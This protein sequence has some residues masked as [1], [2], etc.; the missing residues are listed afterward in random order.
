MTTSPFE[1]IIF[2][3]DGTLIDTESADLRA[4]Q[5]IY[6]EHGATI[7]PEY[8]AKHIVGYKDSA[9]LV[10]AD[11][12]QRNGHGLSAPVL[13]QRFRELWSNQLDRV[14]LLP[15]VPE[16]LLALQAFG[17]PLALAT[18]SD[19]TWTQRWLSHFNLSGYFQAIA[20]CE[21]V[22]CNKPAPDVY[23]FAAARIGVLPAR[24]LVFEDSLPGLA[25]AKSAG[26]TAVA[27]R[28]QA[29]Q[30]IEFSQADWVI[31]SLGSV[32]VEWIQNLNLQKSDV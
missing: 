7:S 28:H 8:W 25:A 3:L 4:C 31:N 10:V 2:D 20:T 11:L 27:V 16:L 15:G 6:Q 17:V 13:R 21:D 23:L 24:C 5:L 14:E 19:R 30:Y 1:T 9:E 26:M 29:T 18:A 12:L 22:V 32:T